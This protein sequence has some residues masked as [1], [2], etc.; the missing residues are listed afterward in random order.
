VGVKSPGFDTASLMRRASMGREASWR[1]PR[2]RESIRL[3]L[4]SSLVSID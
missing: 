3:R 1:R 4:T 2:A